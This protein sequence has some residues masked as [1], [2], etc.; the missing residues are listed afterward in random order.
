MAFEGFDA[1]SQGSEGP[2]LSWSARGTQ[3]GV[4]PPRSFYLNDKNAGKRIVDAFA[5]G[6]VL[7]IETMRTGWQ[8]DGGAVGV[9]P[10]WKLGDSPARLPAKPGEGWKKGFQLRVALSPTEAASWNQSGAGAWGAFADLA[11]ALTAGARDN[12]GKLPVVRM[13]SV[14]E[15]KFTKGSTAQPVLEIIKWTDRPA[16][17]REQAAA[18]GFDTGE[19][20]PAPAPQ[21]APAPAPVAHADDF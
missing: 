15:I 17:L 13:A 2:W 3:D 8:E 19:A 16:A 1:G 11:T 12:P 21:P 18:S 5:R 4:I 10:Q 20:R 7:D 9:A 14:K 6:V